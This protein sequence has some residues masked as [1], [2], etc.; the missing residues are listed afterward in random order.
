MHPSKVSR[1]QLEK[2][3]DLPNIGPACAA[4]LR[5]L[6]IDT[7]D[8][9]VGRCP[10]EMYRQLCTLTGKVQDPC[11]L[12]VFLSISDFM[13]GGQ[14]KRWWAYTAERKRLMNQR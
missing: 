12:D 14:A 4:D 8:D 13:A 6:G 5:R 7:P 1:R 2:L 3:A 10:L 11:V 9:L